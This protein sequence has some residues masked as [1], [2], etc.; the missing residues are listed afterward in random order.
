MAQLKKLVS[1]LH[2]HRRKAEPGSKRSWIRFRARSPRASSRGHRRSDCLP[3]GPVRRSSEAGIPPRS[4]SSWRRQCRRPRFDS[5][6]S[7]TSKLRRWSSL[8]PSGFSVSTWR[9]RC[10][11]GWRRHVLERQHRLQH[12]AVGAT[13]WCIA[14]SL[15]FAAAAIKWKTMKG[16]CVII[17]LNGRLDSS[18]N[19]KYL[20]DNMTLSQENIYPNR[21]FVCL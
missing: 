7:P 13:R 2:S 1:H 12:R 3:L 14:T 20:N 9:W 11:S 15:Q 8:T 6:S 5:T 4:R 16:F 21:Q 18:G 10:S 19:K 17:F